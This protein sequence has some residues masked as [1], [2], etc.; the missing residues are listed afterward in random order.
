MN[1]LDPVK[2]AISIIEKC[3]AS[4]LGSIDDEGY[5]NVKAMLPPREHDGVKTFF[6]TTNTSSLRVKQY[7]KNPKASVYFYDAGSFLGVMLK[8]RMEV[9]MD[10]PTKDRIWR[11]GDTMYYS[12]GVTDPDYCV[13]KFTVENGRLYKDFSSIDF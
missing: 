12:K 1:K 2:T 10:Q 8:G 13:L 7:V 6:F 11:K 3:G 5:P 9:M 4:L